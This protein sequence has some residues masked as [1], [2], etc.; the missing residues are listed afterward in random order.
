MHERDRGG[1]DASG[2]CAAYRQVRI[3]DPLEPGTLM[4]PLVEPRGGRRHDGRARAS[5]ASRA[6][7][8]LYGGEPL[9]DCPAAATSS[10]RSCE[11]RADMPIVQR[12]DLRADPLPAASTTTLDEA[13]AL[14]NDVPQGLSSR[15]LHHEPARRPRRS[16]RARGTDCGIAN[17]NIGT[18]GAEIGGAFGG[19]KET[20]GGRESGSDAW[21]AY[22]RRQTITINWSGRPAAGAGHPVRRLI[23]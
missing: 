20:G 2:W 7:E 13:I 14:H 3:G 8:I 12:G 5:R 18:T 6:G 10:R 22:M 4:G 23:T 15:D 17:V 21:K 9:G 11:A 19:E 1:V 16:S